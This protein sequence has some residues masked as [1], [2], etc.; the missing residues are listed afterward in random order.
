[1]ISAVR[2]SCAEGRL[3]TFPAQLQSGEVCIFGGLE[4]LAR[5]NGSRQSAAPF[6]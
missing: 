3:V 2:A 1:V 5:R 6:L 4:Q